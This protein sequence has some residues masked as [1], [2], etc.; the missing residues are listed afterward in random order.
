MTA[1]RLITFNKRER[2]RLAV[3][4]KA[5]G[6]RFDEFVHDAA[7]QACDEMEGT[8]RRV[9]HAATAIERN[10][11]NSVIAVDE[12]TQRIAQVRLEMNA[13]SKLSSDPGKVMIAERVLAV[14]EGR[15]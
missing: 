9:S 3:Q 7:M 12:L 13:T 15:V 6:I 14:L 8:Q 1:P 11:E 4:C 10:F 5:L 2:A